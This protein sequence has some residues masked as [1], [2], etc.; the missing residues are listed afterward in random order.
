MDRFII[1]GGNPLCGTPEISA[2]KNSAL[3]ILAASVVLCGK[4]HIKNC[5]E[6]CDVAV[7]AD[8][9]ENMG[10]KTVFKGNELTIDASGLKTWGLPCELT[11]KIRA[12][13]FIV[14]AL[15]TRF[16][17]AEICRAGG[18]DIGDRPIDIHID[19]LRALG[20]DVEEG[21]TV[22][23]KKKKTTGGRVRLRYPS[24][25]A[26]ENAMLYA[27]GLKGESVIEN[28]AREPEIVDLQN[29]LNLLGVKVSGAG[30]ERITVC[31][32]GRRETGEVYFEP[33]KDRIEAGTFL[34]AG[35]ICGGEM[36][37]EARDLCNLTAVS[38]ILSNNACK[39]RPKNDKIVCVEYCG[40][41]KGFGK[42][43]V[44]PYPGF[45]TD[46]QPQLVAAASF[47]RGVTVV[48]E[49]VFPKRFNYVEELLKTGADISVGGNLCAVNGKA[50]LVGATM[51]AG[52]L[53]GGAAL[54]I[55]A[56]GADGRSQILGVNHIDRGYFAFEKKL[57]ALGADVSRVSV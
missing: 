1:N 18:C 42:V 33:S 38:K 21:E 23:F 24:V 16:G 8:I 27:A 46:L 51:V 45:P 4:T 7:M 37:F 6:I 54:A 31:G 11:K 39:I 20:A 2:A 44:S 28:A 25:G 22:K 14:G 56:L 34:L 36:Q 10:G 30:G 55:A 29:F 32:D 48:E 26:T 52:D 12:S 9:I 5:P 57:R 15:L 35:A 41:K 53:R 13:L 50:G 49:T 47:A 40:L 43:V 19:A 3:P 17:A